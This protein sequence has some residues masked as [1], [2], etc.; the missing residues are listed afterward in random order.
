MNAK[1]KHCSLCHRNGEAEELYSSHNLKA[2]DGVTIACPILRNHVC[3][4]CGATGDRAHTL[5]HCPVNKAASS[6]SEARASSL[7]PEAKAFD[8]TK[9]WA[10]AVDCPGRPKLHPSARTFEAG[11]RPRLLCQ[12]LPAAYRQQEAEESA[13][14]EIRRLETKLA[15]LRHAYHSPASYIAMRTFG[16]FRPQHRAA[17]PLASSCLLSS[18]PNSSTDSGSAFTASSD[19]GW[20]YADLVAWVESGE[21]SQASSEDS[22]PEREDVTTLLAQLRLGSTSV[23]ELAVE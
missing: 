11:G 18:S 15:R 5:K 2:R 7:R 9:A 8:S 6:L 23:P 20:T 4:V 1:G 16:A 19:K 21:G 14:S 13:A 10:R 3:T 22:D 17:P 12:P